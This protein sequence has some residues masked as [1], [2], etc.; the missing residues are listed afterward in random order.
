MVGDLE[1]WTLTLFCR[2]SVMR[3]CLQASS[4]GGLKLVVHPRGWDA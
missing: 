3:K 1:V 4:G 2:K